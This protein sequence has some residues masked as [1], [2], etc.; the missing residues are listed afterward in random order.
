MAPADTTVGRAIVARA[1][2]AGYRVAAVVTTEPEEAGGDAGPETL[3]WTATSYLGTKNVVLSAVNTLGSVDCAV[4]VRTSGRDPHAVHQMSPLAIDAHVDADIK[5]RLFLVREILNHFTKARAGM[6][7]FVLH[8]PT[9]EPA[10]PLD[11][12]ADA[13]FRAFVD[14][15]FTVY[16]NEPFHLNAFESHSTNAEQYA[17]YILQQIESRAAETTGK[18]YRHGATALSRLGIR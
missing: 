12:A 15:V 9:D 18:W 13:H 5:A 16:Q 4:V 10:S 11:I 17:E 1:Q 7:E 8:Q 2:G 3:T 6:L 14:S